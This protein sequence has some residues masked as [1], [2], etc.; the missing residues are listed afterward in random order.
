MLHSVIDFLRTRRSVAPKDMG[1]AMPSAEALEQILTIA[2]RVPDHGK[3]APWRIITFDK[4]AQ[5]AFGEIVAQRFIA[6]NP[7]A[8]EAQIVFE[9]ARPMR[10][11]LMLVVLS[12][13]VMGKIPVWEQQLSAGA[14]CMNMLHATH[15]LGFGAKWLTEW[16]AYDEVMLAA[17][18]GNL[19]H[20]DKVAGFIYIGD[21]NVPPEE[22]ERPAL[23]VVARKWTASHQA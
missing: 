23:E 2:S 9:R 4:A 7:E 17:L 22:R 10:A 8:T 16:I 20:Q 18:G 6:L 19:E 11:P 3:L 21:I 14:V 13:P 12:T 1:Q 15:A 5:A